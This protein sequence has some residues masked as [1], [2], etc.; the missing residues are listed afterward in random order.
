V[1]MGVSDLFHVWCL[2]Q[3]VS[4]MGSLGEL[5][6]GWCRRGMLLMLMGRERRVPFFL[7]DV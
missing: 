2:C 1:G 7:F 5:G 4:S 3:V 6:W